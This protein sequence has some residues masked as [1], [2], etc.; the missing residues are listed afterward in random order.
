MVSNHKMIALTAAVVAWVWVAAAGIAQ[1]EPAGSGG[2]VGGYVAPMQQK[3]RVVFTVPTV[4]CAAGEYSAAYLGVAI[5]DPTQSSF[6][7]VNVRCTNGT[8]TYNDYRTMGGGVPWIVVSPGDVMRATLKLSTGEVVTSKIEDLT[9]DEGGF[10]AVPLPGDWD[11]GSAGVWAQGG[12][13]FTDFGSADVSAFRIDGQA[14]NATDADGSSLRRSGVVLA[15][16]SA[17]RD[18]GAFTVTWRHG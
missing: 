15:K 9:T 18:G 11:H 6:S 3:A 13:P 8:P 2:A 16:V 12:D 1:A 5:T 10:S 4:T 14:V 7:G 17:L